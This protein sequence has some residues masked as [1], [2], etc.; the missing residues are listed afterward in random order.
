MKI[1]KALKGQ[2]GFTLIEMLI[3]VA[4]IAVL[5]AISVPMVNRDLEKAREAT[6]A[7]NERAAKSAAMADFM[8]DTPTIFKDTNAHAYSAKDGKFVSEATT[9]EKYGKSKANKDK[10]ITVKLDASGNVTELKW[11]DVATGE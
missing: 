2:C 10:Y 11:N 4:I 3:V 8:L 9:T 1:K 6:D 5:V 7:A